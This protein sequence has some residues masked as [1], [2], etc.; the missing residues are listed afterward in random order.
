MFGAEYNTVAAAAE[1]KVRFYKGDKTAYFVSSMIA[2]I[3]VGICMITILVMAGMMVGFAG[4]KILQGVSFAAALSLVIFGGADLF[5]GNVFVMTAGV[6]RGTVSRRDAFGLCTLCYIGNFA[7]SALIAILFLWTGYLQGA[8]LTEA[9]NA[10]YAKTTPMF[11]ELLVRGILCNMLVCAAVWCAYKLQS[12]SAKLIM[13]FWCIYLFV[14]CGFEHCIANMTLFSMGFM[15]S[16]DKAPPMAVNLLATTLG[17]IIGGWLLS[18]AY[19]VIGRK[20]V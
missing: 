9:A 12:E 5:T 6:V 2:G 17:N 1:K 20:T 11:G 7:G 8:V 16:V 4:I 13:I 14:V 15:V 3:C 18:V 10:V 19:W